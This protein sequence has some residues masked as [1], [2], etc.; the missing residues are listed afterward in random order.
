MK[1]KSNYISLTGNE[2]STTIAKKIIEGCEIVY[3][4]YLSLLTIEYGIRPESLDYEIA[5][6][7]IDLMKTAMTMDE[8]PRI[9]NLPGVLA[10]KKVF[11]V[12][13]KL[14]DLD[15]ELFNKIKE[16]Y[17]EKYEKANSSGCLGVII[18]IPIIK[19]LA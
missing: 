3:I 9:R 2:N 7:D 15:K 18:Q 14:Y 11:K 10:R 8:D 16:I 6:W 1:N 12:L 5:K 13:L 19:F 17:N 4:T